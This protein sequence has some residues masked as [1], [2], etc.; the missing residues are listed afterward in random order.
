[1]TG[2]GGGFE[3]LIYTDCRPGESVAGTAGMGFRSRSPGADAAAMTLVQR[4]LLYEVPD[5]WMRESRPIADYPRCYAHTWDRYVA[6]ASGVY[7][8]RELTGS[9]QGN[10]LTH[11]IV[12]QDPRSY[13]LVRPAQLL[14]APFWA[15]AGDA[16]ADATALSGRLPRGPFD[17]E[18]AQRF[19]R[20]RAG[21][22]ELL[23]ALLTALEQVHTAGARRVLFID[24]DSRR[25]LR[26]LV[27][28]TLL[29]P[30]QQA[31][32]I[33]FKVFTTNPAY[34][35]QHVVAVHPA[36]NSSAARVHNDLGYRVFDLVENEW[37]PAA[38]SQRALH[39]VRLFL[40]EDPFDVVDAVEA[41]AVVGGSAATAP[42]IAAAAVLGHRPKPGPEAE[43]VVNWLRTGS[44]AM[45]D[46]YGARVVDVMLAAVGD[47]SPAILDGIY[48]A[49]ADGR[50]GGRTTGAKALLRVELQRAEHS[51]AVSATKRPVGNVWTADSRA[52]A[53]AAVAGA[54]RRAPVDRI[55]PILRVAKRFDLAVDCA[56]LAAPM[57]AFVRS[58]A[59]DPDAGHDPAAWP[60]GDELL[61]MMRVELADRLAA[62]PQQRWQIGT[63]WW[64]RLPPAIPPLD[65]LD[66]ALIAAQTAQQLG[67][68]RQ[69]FVEDA[70]SRSL[71]APDRANALNRTVRALY[72]RVPPR[73]A[74]AQ[75]LR[76]SAAG[77]QLDP[78]AFQTWADQLHATPGGNPELLEVFAELTAG[79]LYSPDAGL[80]RL[81]NEG[82]GVSE[83]LDLIARADPT[84]EDAID[85]LS[86]ASKRALQSRV[87]DTYRGLNRSTR[88]WLVA[89]LLA[90][91]P[92]L[93]PA[94][95]SRL[96]SWVLT[97]G[98]PVVIQALY[99][100]AA[101]DLPPPVAEAVTPQLRS[102]LETVLQRWVARTHTGPVFD[103]VDRMA[104]QLGGP[105]TTRWR[106]IVSQHR[107]QPGERNWLGFRRRGG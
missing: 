104:Q 39:W 21:G 33:G 4:H 74:E 44:P 90:Q 18:E 76:R 23:L 58:W 16:A 32:R 50:I 43:A 12:T 99:F 68:E 92:E 42:A 17:A 47:W 107:R 77:L 31:L 69:R 6:S 102:E 11:A 26:W 46:V 14:D 60:C 86:P 8:G 7:L 103:S 81:L 36:W 98:A 28:A 87:D 3:T 84:A 63:D 88:P 48:A 96:Q 72:S 59:D 9:R 55:D 67:A 105:Y 71:M 64:R 51:G 15:S 95:V 25:V 62:N 61:A 65:D 37:T 100:V 66:A 40:S 75:L 30:Q 1:M 79:G 53:E 38:P 82:K 35:T 73:P 20:G 27:A 57:A 13:G 83:L 52:E 101:E 10:H 49:L 34:A 106:T 29:L 85:A 97:G 24:T 89:R 78:M 45:I 22:A 19:V 94:Y 70:V 91:V 41:A 80:R 54:I 5:N 93:A 2:P 56:A